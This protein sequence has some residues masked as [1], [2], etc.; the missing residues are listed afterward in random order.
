[1]KLT[2]EEAEFEALA[3]R[4]ADLVIARLKSIQPP[5]SN[6]AR[7]GEKRKFYSSRE[8]AQY[9]GVEIQTLA[10]WRTSGRYGLP[11]TKVGRLVRYRLEDLEEFAASRT[12]THTR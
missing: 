6:S 9:L 2:F 4:V 12:M 7:S 5:T 10:L 8:A 1:M 3:A 11:F